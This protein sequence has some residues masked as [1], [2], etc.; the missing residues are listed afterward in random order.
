MTI[1]VE[2]GPEAEAELV[3]GAAVRG[4]SVEEYAQELLRNALRP[5]SPRRGHLSREEAREMIRAI[6]EGSEKLPMLPTSAF[7]R[8]SFYEDR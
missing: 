5:P 6:G 2:L 1:Q 7:S 3:S 8:E 4:V